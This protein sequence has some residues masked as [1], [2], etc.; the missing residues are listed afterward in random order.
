MCLERK[1]HI[2]MIISI[3]AVILE[4]VHFNKRKNRSSVIDDFMGNVM[5]NKIRHFQN[6]PNL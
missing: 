4:V 3:N 5:F 6:L 1:F 2:L